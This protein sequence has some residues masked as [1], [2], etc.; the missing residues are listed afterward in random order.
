MK[1]TLKTDWT[2]EEICQGFTFDES[3]GKGLYGLN[4]QLIIQPEYQ[5]NYIYDK[6]DKDKDVIYSLLSGYPI[7]LM[8]FVKNK[9]GQYEVLDGQQRITSIGRFVN[10]SYT[11]SIIDGGEEKHFDRLTPFQQKLIKDTKL[12]IYICE[13]EPSEIEEWFKKINIQGVP[14][15]PQELRNASY[16]GKFVTLARTKFSNSSNANMN[17]WRTY[18]KGDPKRQE[19]LEVALDWV[20]N[21]NIEEYMKVHREDD[22]IKELETYFNSVINWITSVFEYTDKEVKGLPWGEYYK[23]YHSKFYDKTK[24]T[25]RVDELMSDPYVHNKKGIFEYILGEEKH[26]ELLQIRLFDDTIK[27]T[28]YSIQTSEAKANGTSNCPLCALGIDNNSRKIWDYKNM[29]ADHV[30]A[31]SKGGKTD[32]KNCKMLC[33]THNRAKGN[34]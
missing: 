8:Y 32:I 21:G 34:K 22:N 30:E 11:F 25:K 33:V 7:G 24:V 14:L 12:T 31:W 15:T 19:I 16:H 29:D 1:T 20:S 17:K 26:P 6:G 4:G 28:V 3:E 9:D 10:Q 5:R 27:R 2:I 18:I 13:G 23:K